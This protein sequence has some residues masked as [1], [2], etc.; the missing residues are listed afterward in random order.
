M[1]RAW[2]I[3]SVT[4]VIACGGDTRAPTDPAKPP[5]TGPVVAFVATQP[6]SPKGIWVT[7]LTGKSRALLATDTSALQ[8]PAWSPDGASLAFTLVLPD[9]IEI[10]VMNADG[11]GRKRILNGQKNSRDPAW[12]PDGQRLAFA[13]GPDG[14]DTILV[15]NRDGSNVSVLTS[16][17]WDDG[18]PAWSPNGQ[19]IAFTSLRDPPVNNVSWRRLFLMNAD[20]S[21]VQRVAPDRDLV[22]FSPSWSPDGTQLAF[23]ARPSSAGPSGIYLYTLATGAVRQLTSTPYGDHHPTW[24][25]DGTRIV[26]SRASVAES[27]LFS[28]A[29]DGSDLRQVTSGATSDLDPA[30]RPVR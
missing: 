12:S 4:G 23:E 29:T 27:H 13:S 22:A 6:G 15:M 9:H 16:S 18:E 19:L 28:V 1:T 21:N 26:F 20:G 17:Q 30:F 25:P 8:A 11:S 7:D 14:R 10:D 5:I 24:S 2:L 3:V